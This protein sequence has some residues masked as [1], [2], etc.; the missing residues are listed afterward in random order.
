MMMYEGTDRIGAAHRDNYDRLVA[1]KT[2]CDP[3]NLFHVMKT[4][5]GSL[6]TGACH[7]NP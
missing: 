1:V 2:H 3:T 7:G 6:D 5:S 4:S